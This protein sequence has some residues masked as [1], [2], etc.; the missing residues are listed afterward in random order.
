MNPR[1]I[2]VV[3]ALCAADIKRLGTTIQISNAGIAPGSGVKNS[4]KELSESTLGV[5]VIAVGFP[6]VVDASGI[7]ETNEPFVVTPKDIDLMIDRTATLIGNSLN[8][9][10]QPETDAEILRALV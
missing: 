5:P 8:I 7:F 10:L 3:D 6:T 4:R 2:I 9:A 1:A